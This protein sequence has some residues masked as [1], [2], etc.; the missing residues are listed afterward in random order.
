MVWSR[1]NEPSKIPRRLPKSGRN[2]GERSALFGDATYSGDLTTFSA[3]IRSLPIRDSSALADKQIVC[4]RQ[5][6]QRDQFFIAEEALYQLFAPLRRILA[7]RN[8]RHSSFKNSNTRSNSQTPP[9]SARESEW[10]RMTI[11][12]L[13]SVRALDG[14][15]LADGL[16]ISKGSREL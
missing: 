11:T 13:T 1:A 6:M 8:L 15:D 14:E 7:V 12:V 9:L 3:P 16:V 4:R 10:N 5:A 2:F